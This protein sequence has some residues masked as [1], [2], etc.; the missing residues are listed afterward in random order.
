[1]LFPVCF[2]FLADID[3]GYGFCI[4]DL[5]VGTPLSLGNRFVNC[6]LDKSIERGR[7]NGVEQAFR[8]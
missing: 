5:G 4:L 1:M 6:N 2:G 3:F 8:S 7:F